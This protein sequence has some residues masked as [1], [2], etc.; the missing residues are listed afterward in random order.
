LE[1]KRRRKCCEAQRVKRDHD[2]VGETNKKSSCERRN[3][4]KV[5]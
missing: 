4:E 5:G 1:S 2:R 3:R